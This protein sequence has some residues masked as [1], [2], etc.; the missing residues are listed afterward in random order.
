MKW[1]QCQ[2]IAHAGT[3]FM[4]Q[5]LCMI[6][7]RR[8]ATWQSQLSMARIM[9]VG[10]RTVRRYLAV[11]ESLQIIQRAYR[12]NGRG[13]RTSD[14]I[15]IRLDR[16]F[17]VSRREVRALLKAPDLAGSNSISYRPTAHVLPANLARDQVSD[18]LSKRFKPRELE[19]A[20]GTRDAGAQRAVLRVLGG[21]RAA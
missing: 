10:E 5:T 9:G 4:I 6:V 3:S 19:L 13:G 15:R 11:L 20:S 17:S 2:D 1:L 12:S 16:N 18:P 21:G 14:L 7:D 8:G